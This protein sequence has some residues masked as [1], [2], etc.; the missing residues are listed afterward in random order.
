MITWQ[1]AVE[2]AIEAVEEAA[3]AAS[4]V[5][6]NRDYARAA[7]YAQIS[8]AWSNIGMMLEVQEEAEDAAT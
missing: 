7:T 4:G 5:N 3:K 8:Y 6:Y 2:R 1:E